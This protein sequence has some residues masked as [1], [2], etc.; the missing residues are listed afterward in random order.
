[1]IYNTIK[2]ILFDSIKYFI[3]LFWLAVYLSRSNKIY[4]GLNSLSHFYF[5]PDE[6]RLVI[7]AFMLAKIIDG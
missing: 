6:I 5:K 2:Y 4:L 1:M 3:T 7:Q